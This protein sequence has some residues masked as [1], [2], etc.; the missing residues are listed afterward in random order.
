[1]LR[2]HGCIH[3]VV[4]TNSCEPDRHLHENRRDNYSWGKRQMAICNAYRQVAWRTRPSHI[5]NSG[6]RET[7]PN[8]TEEPNAA[9]IPFPLFFFDERR[10][11]SRCLAGLHFISEAIFFSSSTNSFIGRAEAI[12]V[13]RLAK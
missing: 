1:M 12:L 9:P 5:N 4:L 13:N 2:L 7:Q 10:L 8:Q 6:S 3:L 11:W